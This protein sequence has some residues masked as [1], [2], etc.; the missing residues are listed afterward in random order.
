M[1]DARDIAAILLAAG[2][3]RRFGADDK[4]LAPLAGEPLA[5][6]AARRIVE[7]APGRRIAVCRDGDGQLARRLAALDFE[8][9]V[10]PAPEAGLS[11]SL[12]C[13]IAEAARGSETAALIALADMPFV[14]VAHLRRLLAR[15]DAADA[16]VVA[17]TDGSTAMPPALFAR[18]LFGALQEGKGDRGAKTL[19]ADAALVAAGDGELADIDRPED[20]ES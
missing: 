4:L 10:N 17:S 18:S 8:I 9:V 15:F 5:L 3:S 19:L 7:L 11:Q 2:G 20:L 14:G 6:H 13:G 1:I 12:A 16:P